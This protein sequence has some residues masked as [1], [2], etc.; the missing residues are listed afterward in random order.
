MISQQ[1]V[2]KRVPCTPD[3]FTLEYGD[4]HR[5]VPKWLQRMPESRQKVI[6]LADYNSRRNAPAGCA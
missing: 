6:R 5:V 4:Y 1:D 3:T 2:Q